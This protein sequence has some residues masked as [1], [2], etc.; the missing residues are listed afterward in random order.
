MHATLHKVNIVLWSELL[1][2]SV[3]LNVT[4]PPTPVLAK[5]N[6]SHHKQDQGTVLSRAHTGIN[7]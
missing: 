4:M 5:G 6:D 2:G 7:Y 1:Y 3:V